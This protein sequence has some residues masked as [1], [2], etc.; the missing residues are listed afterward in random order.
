MLIYAGG[1]VA[2]GRSYRTEADFAER[3]SLWQTHWQAFLDR[4][5]I[6]HGLNTFRDINAHYATPEHWAALHVVG[7]AHNIYIQA[8]EETGL[9]GMALFTAM[10]AGPL[11]RAFRQAVHGG[12][13]AELAAG[14]IGA[15]VMCLM[16]GLVDF[17][18][19]TPAIAALL[20]YSLASSANVGAAS[21]SESEASEAE[22]D[23]G[24]ENA[25]QRSRSAPD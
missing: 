10:L 19:Q 15:T 13:G 8:L 5:L 16:H 17:G 24:P 14:V 4:P 1:H 11:W 9:I 25:T 7:A 2:L 21:D 22:P 12:R 20:A 3:A 6:G 18:L 23:D